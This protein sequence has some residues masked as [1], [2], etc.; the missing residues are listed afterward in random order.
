[1]HGTGSRFLSVT[2]LKGDELMPRIIQIAGACAR[3][4]AVPVPCHVRSSPL[5][6]KT[7]HPTPPGVYPGLTVQEL[8]APTS[9]ESPSYGRWAY[10]FSDPEGPQ[11]GTVALPA[12][13]LVHA[14]VDPVV[15]IANN[16]ALNIDMRGDHDVEV[17][18]YLAWQ[19]GI[20]VGLLCSARRLIDATEPNHSPPPPTTTTTQKQIQALV[21][22]DRGDRYFQSNKFYA[23]GAPDGSVVI[24]WF[25]QVPPE[26][27]VVGRVQYVTVPYMERSGTYKSGWMEL[28]DE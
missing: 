10:D 18:A 4:R 1:M 25:D 14:C 3:G 26:Y 7:T 27:T 17:R 23:F 20:V 13:S 24:R 19:F 16:D 28:D 15:V 12:S 9:T 8:L 5:P 21:L 22:I 2:Q 6:T 11:M